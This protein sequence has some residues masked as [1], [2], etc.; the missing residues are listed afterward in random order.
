MT[1][2][3][4]RTELVAPPPLAEA[5]ATTNRVARTFALACRLLPRAIRADVYRL[6]VVFR[7]LDDLVDD[8]RQQS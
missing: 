7:A 6:Y 4:P 3:V 8:V 1:T 5:R 2:V